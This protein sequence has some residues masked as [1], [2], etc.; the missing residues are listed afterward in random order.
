MRQRYELGADIATHVAEPA[1]LVLPLMLLLLW[2]T[3]RR[4]LR[5]LDRLSQEVETLDGFA[6]QRLD[7]RHRFREFGST[8]SA[9]NGLVDT[10]Q[11]RAQRERAFASDVAHELRTPLAALALQRSEEH[12]SE[13]Q[14]H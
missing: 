4:G 2:W 11:E 9:I 5:P 7:T 6:G 3:V 14:S 12:T 10:L 8:V 1:L 13:L